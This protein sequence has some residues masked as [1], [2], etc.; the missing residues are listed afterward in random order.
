[1]RAVRSILADLVYRWIGQTAPPGPAAPPLMSDLLEQPLPSP[2]PLSAE[3]VG[4]ARAEGVGRLI[5][6]RALSGQT[7]SDD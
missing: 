3:A 5:A 2:A 1:M 7:A 4:A 6:R